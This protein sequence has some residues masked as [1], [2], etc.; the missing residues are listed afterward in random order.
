MVTLTPT[1]VC[2]KHIKAIR[3]AA[4]VLILARVADGWDNVT[5]DYLCDTLGAVTPAAR[6]SVLWAVRE[7][8]DEGVLVKSGARGVY[9]VA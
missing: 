7:A 5:L 1:G 9:S 6:N 4:S 2:K 3:Q 8:K